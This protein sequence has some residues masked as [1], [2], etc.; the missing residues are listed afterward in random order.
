MQDTQAETT[1]AGR[2]YG[3]DDVDYATWYSDWMK[4]L[5]RTY[6]RQE[7]E[8]RLYGASAEAR[9]CAMAHFRAIEATCGMQSQSARRAHARNMTAAAG[10]TAIAIRGALEIHDLF[11][12]M[13]AGNERHND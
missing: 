13:A 8:A 11:P 10:D 2:Q 12:E 9:R 3:R 5:A 6:T 4:Q 7:L 1:E